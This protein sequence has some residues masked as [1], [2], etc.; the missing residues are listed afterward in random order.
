MGGISTAIWE[1]SSIGIPYYIYEPLNMGLLDIQ[2]KKSILF[3]QNK[4]A[5]DLK[6]L[7]NKIRNKSHFK[8]NKSLMFD[9]TPLD[10]LK[11]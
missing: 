9:G 8:I 6:E 5:R 3:N 11:L 10:E 7:E 4:C 1:A 2:I